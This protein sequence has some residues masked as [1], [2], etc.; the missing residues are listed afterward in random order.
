[1]IFSPHARWCEPLYSSSF[2]IK[3]FTIFLLRP[4]FSLQY[5]NN[6]IFL[7]NFICVLPMNRWYCNFGYFLLKDVSPS[8]QQY[9][10]PHFFNLY[11]NRNS[12]SCAWIGSSQYCTISTMILHVPPMIL[13]HSSRIDFCAFQT[14]M[15]SM[16]FPLQNRHKIFCV[17]KDFCG[18]THNIFL[19]VI[20]DPYDRA[21]IFSSLTIMN[22]LPLLINL[23][24]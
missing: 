12:A 18:Y 1:M 22:F 3:R 14:H 4:Y 2:S 13:L 19:L 9:A 24:S 15:L 20:Q 23:L 7:V 5:E 11:I 8:L 6:S 21:Y 17:L 16:G 10:S